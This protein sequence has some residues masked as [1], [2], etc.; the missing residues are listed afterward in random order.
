M[1][2][3]VHAGS[4]ARA[5]RGMPCPSG[6]GSKPESVPHRQQAHW[7][8]P[9]LWSGQPQVPSRH[10]EAEAGPNHTLHRDTPPVTPRTKAAVLRA[11]AS[12]PSSLL[13]PPLTQAAPSPKLVQ[14]CTR[15]RCS[16]P[17]H[18]QT[19]HPAPRTPHPKPSRA[20]HPDPATPSGARRLPG[21]GGRAQAVTAGP[22]ERAGL[23]EVPSRATAARWEAHTMKPM[24]MGA[25]MGMWAVLWPRFWSVATRTTKTRAKVSTHSSSH[26]AVPG[27]PLSRR[28][29]PPRAAEKPVRSV[30]A[31]RGGGGG[32][33]EVQKQAEHKVGEGG[34]V[35]VE[36][37]A[38]WDLL[39]A[40]A[41]R[42]EPQGGYCCTCT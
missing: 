37:R 4:Q 31:G 34:R 20:L 32:L 15:L 24:A 1:L 6:R 40:G 27:R 42:G 28:L 30:C 23:M 17:R 8:Q 9:M 35:G 16:Q 33:G 25:R 5:C 41:A 18:P 38:F 36:G 39:A 19:P 22:K 26:P 2:Q 12:S 10:A 11:T 21:S 14:A 3:G 29:A 13:F 7:Q